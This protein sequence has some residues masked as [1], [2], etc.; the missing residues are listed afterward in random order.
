MPR[1]K[2]GFPE[3]ILAAL[4]RT[5]PIRSRAMFGGIG[6]YREDVFFAILWKGRL[7]LKSRS[8]L[9]VAGRRLK[10]FRPRPTLTM[11]SYYEVPAS[12]LSNRTA[13]LRL[14]RA[15]DPA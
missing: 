6:L 1:P 14:I 2:V 4:A 8:P 12:A 7:Y 10:P 11:S 9:V 3:D 13:L 15:A 5:G